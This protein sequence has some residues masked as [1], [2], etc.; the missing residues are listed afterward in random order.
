[1]RPQG[2]AHGRGRASSEHAFE[3]SPVV[4]SIH[5]DHV[6]RRRLAIPRRSAGSHVYTLSSPVA[7]PS[8]SSDAGHRGPP[9]VSVV[10]PMRDAEPFIRRAIES[11]L[12]QT[13]VDLELIVVD[14]GSKDRGPE[15]VGA[16]DDERIRLIRLPESRGISAALNEGIAQARAPYIGRMDADDLSLPGRF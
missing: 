12:A 16:L 1:E 3:A 11:V 14:D 8:S 13:D 15:I 4:A 5:A 10:V 7:A 9:A 6:H 2:V